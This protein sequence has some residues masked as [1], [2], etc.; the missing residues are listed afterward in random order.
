MLSWQWVWGLL[1]FRA[2]L[3]Y[4]LGNLGV[5]LAKLLILESPKTRIARNL[6]P[7]IIR[8]DFSIVV[9]SDEILAQN[10]LPHWT[11]P[12]IVTL[13]NY[14]IVVKSW[15]VCCFCIV[16]SFYYVF[17]FSVVVCTTLVVGFCIMTYAIF[18]TLVVGF[19]TLLCN[20]HDSLPTL[21]GN[22]PL[23]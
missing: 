14:W 8:F 16:V 17:V 6:M 18:A 7:W 20:Q 12:V 21:F 10:F 3:V 23:L 5:D 1:P 19:W 22:D 11:S 15:V 4:P 9:C 13:F 2:F